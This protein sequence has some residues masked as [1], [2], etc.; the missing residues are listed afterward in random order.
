MH[1]PGNELLA[2]YQTIIPPSSQIVFT[3][4]LGY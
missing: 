1:N 2:R 3:V 4:R